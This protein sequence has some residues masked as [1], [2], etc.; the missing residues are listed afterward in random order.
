MH[1]VIISNFFAEKVKGKYAPEYLEKVVETISIHPKTGK[2]IGTSKNLYLYKLGIC[3]HKKYEYNLI[4]FFENK[5]TSVY[6]INLFK[7]GES[8]ILNKAVSYLAC[9]A[10]K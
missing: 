6:I 2:N 9:D 7:D 10:M 8:D 3:D 5:N 1:T 4:Y